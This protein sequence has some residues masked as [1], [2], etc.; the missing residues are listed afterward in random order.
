V[1]VWGQSSLFLLGVAVQARLFHRFR[2]HAAEDMLRFLLDADQMDGAFPYLSSVGKEYSPYADVVQ[3]Q[4]PCQQSVA[5][6]LDA[7]PPQLKEG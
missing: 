2:R 3:T 1:I 4:G 7:L 5:S 6:V